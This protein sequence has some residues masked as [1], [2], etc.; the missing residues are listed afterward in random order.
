[1]TKFKVV[2]IESER[3]CGQ[4]VD[5]VR[6]FDT[7]EEAAIFRDSINSKN[8]AGRAPDYYRQANDPVEVK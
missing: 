8:P 3:D 1:M 2:V 4:S 7:Y 6:Y 5:E